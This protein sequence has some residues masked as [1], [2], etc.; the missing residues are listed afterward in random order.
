M[1]CSAWPAS[2]S[3][4]I[5]GTWEVFV[6]GRVNHVL[7]YQNNV[8][9]IHPRRVD[10][11][12]WCVG[13]V[14]NTRDWFRSCES[15][16]RETSI[17]VSQLVKAV[18]E[19]TGKPFPY[20]IPPEIIFGEG[21]CLIIPLLGTWESIK[22]MNTLQTAD[23]LDD[24]VKALLPPVP[25]FSGVVFES[26]QERSAGGLV[27]LQFDIYDIVLAEF[28]SDIAAV[29]PQI[30]ESKRPKINPQVFDTF[31]S[32]Y[33]CPVALC[34]FNTADSGTAKPLGF[35]FE[36]MY[37]DKLVVYTMDG[38]EGGPPDPTADVKLDHDI[39]VGSYLMKAEK[40]ARV[41][42][43]NP[44]PDSLRPYI[45]EDILGAHVE[46]RLE[47]GDIIF[48]TEAVRAGVLQGIRSLPPFGPHEL[49]RQGHTVTRL[50][51]YKAY[52]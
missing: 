25:P 9:K 30:Q 5:T 48:S 16:M 29:L 39:F 24:I 49:P 1:C 32:W 7:W 31:N 3:K 8:G 46:R 15:P 19:K 50:S 27:F 17:S 22:L 44:I 35:A 13:R 43:T 10:T 41:R 28:A 4:T 37:P 33:R 34:C 45:L 18:E 38:H 52:A 40:F 51:E 26:I 23:L 36:P 21:N 12:E 20:P 6:D 14:A 2:F 42:Y 11:L 47:N